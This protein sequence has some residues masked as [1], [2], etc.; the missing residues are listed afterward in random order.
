MLLREKASKGLGWLP[1]LTINSKS[2]PPLPSLFH[3]LPETAQ[4]AFISTLLGLDF[5]FS[6]SSTIVLEFPSESILAFTFYECV[7]MYMKFLV[8][9]AV[10]IST[11]I[12]SS[13]LLYFFKR[14]ILGTNVYN[15]SLCKTNT[16]TCYTMACWP[17]GEN[18]CQWPIKWHSTDVMAVI[19]CMCM[20][21]AAHT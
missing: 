19:V 17:N 10:P 9:I 13:V 6:N 2:R 7:C 15:L 18:I 8:W 5:F 4:S 11:L 1:F 20:L 3:V 12:T 21:Y 16:V 14:Y